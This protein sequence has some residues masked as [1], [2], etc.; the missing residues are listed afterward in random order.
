MNPLEPRQ[1][2]L[3]DRRAH[4]L[5]LLCVGYVRAAVM[6]RSMLSLVLIEIILGEARDTPSPMTKRGRI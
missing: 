6:A 1:D 3:A 2:R 5:T 4:T